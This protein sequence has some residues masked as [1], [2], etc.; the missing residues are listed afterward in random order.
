M[1]SPFEEKKDELKDELA[2][3]GDCWAALRN[4]ITTTGHFISAD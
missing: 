1:E 4:G 2:L 3:I